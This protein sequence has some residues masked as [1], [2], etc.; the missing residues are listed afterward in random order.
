LR[1][2]ITLS[3][4]GAVIDEMALLTNGMV[5]ARTRAN[6]NGMHQSTELFTFRVPQG[7]APVVRILS[8]TNGAQIVSGGTEARVTL[9]V[10]AFDL[11]GFL[12]HVVVAVDGVPVS[13]NAVGNF[14]TEV[15]VSGTGSHTLSVTAIDTAGESTTETVTFEVGSSE[16]P[17]PV[18]IAREG[19]E[20]VVNY[21]GERL[22][23]STDLLNWI[24]VHTAQDGGG[25]EYRD[26]GLEQYRFFRGVLD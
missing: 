21:V 20:I 17:P 2:D 4:P 23:G 6:T 19:S 14:T 3:S 7:L 25:A 13:A 12:E 26:S 15:M 8:P 9:Q 11:D 24:D 10:Q 18:E 22:Q 5:L 16:V 1:S